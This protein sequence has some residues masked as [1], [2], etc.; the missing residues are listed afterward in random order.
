MLLPFW[1]GVV[2]VKKRIFTSITIKMINTYNMAYGLLP[3]HTAPISVSYSIYTVLVFYKIN[4]ISNITITTKL[5]K[6]FFNL[7]DESLILSVPINSGLKM[8]TIVTTKY[9]SIHV[10]KE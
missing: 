5:H 1:V 7:T 10:N 3:T 4:M 8:V 9:D 2:K 6:F